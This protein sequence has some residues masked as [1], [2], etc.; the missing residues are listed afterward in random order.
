MQQKKDHRKSY[1]FFTSMLII[2]GVTA[3]YAVTWFRCYNKVIMDPFLSK[4][5]WLIFAL[6]ALFVILF[7]KIYGGYRVGHLQSGGIIYSS[8]LSL[9]IV[10]IVTYFQISLIGRELMAVLPM[11]ILTIAQGILIIIWTLSANY[12][13]GFFY[14]A[15]RMLMV[16]SG[17]LA[18]SL[19]LKMSS[20]PEKYII[21]QTLNIDE[22]LPY[23]CEKM[24]EFDA[25]VLC[26]IKSPVRNQLLKYCYGHSI[27]TYL[28]PKISDVILRGSL[29]VDLFDT[30]LLLCPS[31]G[32]SPEQAFLKRVC[33]LIIA[34]IMALVTS[35]IMLITAMI[36]KLQDGGPVLFKQ[37]RC[38]IN[39][40][41][42]N[43]LKFRSMIVDAEKDGKAHPC[44]DG[45]PRIT[46]FGKFIRKTRIDELPQ[47]FNI[48]KGDMSIVG[49]RPERVEHVQ[50]YSEKIPE[51]KF[52][53]KVKAGLT[54]YAQ[55]AGKYN[56]TAYDKLKLDLMYIEQYS[57]LN[58]F[59]LML[60]TVKILFM[61]ESTEGFTELESRMMQQRDS[62]E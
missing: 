44:I 15:R 3:L 20:R 43:V 50:A 19:V 36:I 61:K 47:L 42:F 37:K 16:Y 39:E 10:N 53:L 38:T 60:M 8:I 1:I 17:K 22:G 54:G 46:P 25:V 45:D 48:L 35:P 59:K 33:D 49:P 29:N 12:L 18:R 40:K 27:R 55:I 58:D 51:F 21:G 6:Y 9:L 41:V 57:L 32:L 31:T 56:T 62:A 28:T 52:R 24:H 14:P 5:N 13:Y 23:I 34:G 26:D 11:V 7:A 4:G 30:P 2:T